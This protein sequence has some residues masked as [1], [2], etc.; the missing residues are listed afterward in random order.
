V[1]ALIDLFESTG[2]LRVSEGDVIAAIE[3][4]ELDR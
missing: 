1:L 2:N 4:G 3:R